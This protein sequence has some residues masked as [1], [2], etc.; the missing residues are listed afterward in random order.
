MI[1]PQD[2]IP[3]IEQWEAEHA[4]LHIIDELSGHLMEL[5]GEDG[6]GA[7]AEAMDDEKMVGLSRSQPVHCW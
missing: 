2:A 1:S 7:G 5:G 6:M 4:F 3:Y